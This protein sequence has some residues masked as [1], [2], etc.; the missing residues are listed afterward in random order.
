MRYQVLDVGVM[1]PIDPPSLNNWI[2]E[3]IL[4]INPPFLKYPSLNEEIV[5]LDTVTNAF[6]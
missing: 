4:S 5:R 3:S 2:I 6:F 1:L